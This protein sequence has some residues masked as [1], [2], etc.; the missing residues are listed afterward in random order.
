MITWSASGILKTL[1]EKE[2]SEDG[3][4][5]TEEEASSIV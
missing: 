4:K 3:E 1:S 5:G 2:M